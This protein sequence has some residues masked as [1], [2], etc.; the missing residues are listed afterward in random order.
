[1]SIIC[2]TLRY[3]LYG[4]LAHQNS[5]KSSPVKPDVKKYLIAV[6]DSQEQDLY[7]LPEQQFVYNIFSV[8]QWCNISPSCI[9]NI[10]IYIYIYIYI[11]SCNEWMIAALTVL[12]VNNNLLH[13][14]VQFQAIRFQHVRICMCLF[15][16]S[17]SFVSPLISF[18][19]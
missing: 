19:T 17:G 5:S 6:K 3:Y 14:I 18:L 1:M 9:S 12:Q 13:Q 8:S 4:Y 10:A 15:K 2:F 11:F 7:C 16:Y